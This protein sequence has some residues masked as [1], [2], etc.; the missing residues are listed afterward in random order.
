MP[1]PKIQKKK[2][3]KNCE[4]HYTN[5]E[6]FTKSKKQDTEILTFFVITLEPI[7]YQTCSARQNDRLNFSFEK[8]IRV[9]GEKNAKN[10]RKTA[11]FQALQ[12]WVVV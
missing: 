3:K 4:K 7:E 1:K 10:G 9:V 2:T 5:E 6:S 8:D 11:N 12:V